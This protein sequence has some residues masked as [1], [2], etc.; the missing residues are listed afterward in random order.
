[1]ADLDTLLSVP[2][3]AELVKQRTPMSSPGP[4]TQLFRMG[5]VDEVDGDRVLYEK[6]RYDRKL[7]AVRAVD[8]ESFTKKMPDRKV[9]EQGLIHMTSKRILTP[10]ELYLTAGVGTFLRS[11]VSSL[12]VDAVEQIKGE[13]FRGVE[14]VCGDLIQNPAGVNL[15]GTN[16]AFPAGANTLSDTLTIEGN[17]QEFT[18]GAGWDVSS[19]EIL[20]GTSQLTDAI[21]KMEENGHEAFHAIHQRSVAKAIVRNI[22]TKEWLTANGGITVEYFKQAVN[23]AARRQGDNADAFSPS[24]WSGI[25]GIPSWLDWDHGYENSAGAFTRHMASDKLILLPRELRRVLGLAEGFSFIPNNVQVFGDAEQAADLF[26]AARGL[27][28]F[29]YR[30]IDDTGNIHIVGRYTFA[31]M[32]RDELGVLTLKDLGT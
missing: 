5:G 12:V 3:L 10:K 19:T 31:P 22:E 7:A 1:M 24:V 4:F 16:T 21:R 2:Y 32:V 13:I 9:V 27:Q 30:S 8:G 29:A 11:N 18:V 17:L 26:R 28:V 25:A 23:A 20:S 6:R 15:S 14:Y